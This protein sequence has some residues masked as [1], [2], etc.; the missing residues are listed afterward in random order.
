MNNSPGP[1]GNVSDQNRFVAYDGSGCN[2]ERH[3]WITRKFSRREN[4]ILVGFNPELKTT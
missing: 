4:L 3:F 2:A 1:D